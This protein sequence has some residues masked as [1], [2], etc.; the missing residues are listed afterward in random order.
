MYPMELGEGIPGEA[1]AMDI[2]TLPWTDSHEEGHRYFL[3]MVDLFSRYVELQPL[4][5]QEA[6]SVLKAFEQGWV[7]RG[8]GMPSIVLTDKGA[9]VAGQ[10]VREFCRRAGINKRRTTPYHPQCDGMAERHIGLVKQVIQCLQADRHLSKGSWPELLTEVSFHINSMKNATSGLSP[11]LLTFGR[12][13]HSPLDAW[14]SNLSEGGRNSHEEYLETLEKK[15]EELESIARSRI[16]RNL[17]KARQR[18]NSGK[19][20]KGDMVMLKRSL[21][22]DALSPRY[23]GPFQVIKRR[24]PDVKVRVAAKDRWVHLNNVKRYSEPARMMVHGTVQTEERNQNM[25]GDGAGVIDPPDQNTNNV[26]A[27]DTLE[28]DLLDYGASLCSDSMSEP[29]ELP[30]NADWDDPSELEEELENRYPRR[31]RRPPKYLTDYSTGEELDSH[32][33]SRRSKN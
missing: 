21:V 16:E 4:K 3:L 31:S 13:P 15:K 18:Y 2:G 17:S 27:E 29:G 7:Y 19:H 30:P 20:E 25:T 9:N 32:K 33:A 28:D 11:H 24:G 6:S 8:H 10:L 14:C 26:T 5:D 1:V 12:E 23:D 22:Q